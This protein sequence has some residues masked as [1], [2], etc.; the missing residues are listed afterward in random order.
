M[1][2]VENKAYWFRILKHF[3]KNHYYENGLTLPFLIGSR[4][5][6]EPDKKLHSIEQ[7]IIEVSQSVTPITMMRCGQIKEYV[8]GIMDYESNKQKHIYRSFKSLI[9]TDDS[10][11]DVSDLPTLI[12]QLKILYNDHI[13]KETFSIIRGDWGGYSETD[14]NRLSEIL[15]S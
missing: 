8:F 7:F 13:N 5:Y 4:K 9:I 12:E 6:L 1:V 14:E 15:T 11:R 2:P 3:E 10:F